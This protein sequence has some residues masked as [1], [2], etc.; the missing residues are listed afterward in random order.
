MLFPATRKDIF[1][2][3]IYSCWTYIL[4][5]KNIYILVGHIFLFTRILVQ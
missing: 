5:G 2:L 3:D 1:L 4:V